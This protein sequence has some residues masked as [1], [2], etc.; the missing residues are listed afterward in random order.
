MIT[1][2]LS[3]EVKEDRRVVLNLPL[4]TPVGKADFVVTIEP[5]KAGATAGGKLRQHFGAVDS[6]D[7]RSG[8][9]DRID[10]D[11]ARAYEASG[12]KTN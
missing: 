1:I 8:D 12:D 7:A 6:G 4:E 2:R 5:H 10:A 3:T 11:L 9:N